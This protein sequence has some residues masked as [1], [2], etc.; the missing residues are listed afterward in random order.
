MDSKYCYLNCSNHKYSSTDRRHYLCCNSC[1]KQGCYARCMEDAAKC[2]YCADV[3]WVNETIE[4]NLN[5][6]HTVN[7]TAPVKPKKKQEESYVDILNKRKQQ[8]NATP[9]AQGQTPKAQEVLTIPHNKKEL[10]QM[11]GVSYD[12]V[13]YRIEVKHKTYE[14]VYEELKK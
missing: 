1:D 5:P 9:I 4:R 2:K 6:W 10:A 14:E 12:K 11:L 13:A 3:T 7:T 8:T